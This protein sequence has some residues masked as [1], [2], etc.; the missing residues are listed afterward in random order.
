VA[1]YGFAPIGTDENGKISPFNDY[2]ASK[3]QAEE[4]LRKWLNTDTENRSLMI[5]RPTAVFGEGNRGNVFNLLNQIASK[6]FI[7]IGRGTNRKSMAY[8]ENLAAFLHQAALSTRYYALTNYVDTPD[9]D[10]NAFVS[11][12][13]K[14]LFGDNSVGLHLPYVFGVSAGYLADWIRMITGKKIPISSIRVK[15]FCAN[16]VFS[17]AK[18]EFDG[19]RA[20]FSLEDGLRRTLEAEFISP[21]PDREIFFTE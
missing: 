12:T 8:V 19:F 14:D 18:E 11:L 9:L 3:Y 15:K 6:Q 21:D 5:V 16:T 2:G 20:S 17:S 4:L 7:M 1:V 10:M 13:R